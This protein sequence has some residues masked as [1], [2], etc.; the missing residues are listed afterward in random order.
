MKLKTKY[1]YRCGMPIKEFFTADDNGVKQGLY[2]SFY[3]NGQIEIKC[4]YK[5]GKKDGPYEEYFDDGR[6]LDIQTYQKGKE[7]FEEEARLYM[8]EWLKNHNFVQ[9]QKNLYV[10][11]KKQEDERKLQLRLIVKKAV[12]SFKD[13]FFKQRQR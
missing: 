4:T 11:I 8:K 5:D 9:M 1:I 13:K 12:V 7:L 10:L 2:M 6:L 3:E